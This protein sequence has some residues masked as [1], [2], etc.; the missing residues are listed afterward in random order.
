MN[1][2]AWC[3][4]W[5]FWRICSTKFTIFAAA[6]PKEYALQLHTI[7]PVSADSVSALLVRLRSLHQQVEVAIAVAERFRGGG[8]LRFLRL[9]GLA[10]PS[11]HRLY[12]VLLMG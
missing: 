7:R 2:L 12:L 10:F 4:N 8:E 3:R 6:K 9:V 11:A 1:I 5:L